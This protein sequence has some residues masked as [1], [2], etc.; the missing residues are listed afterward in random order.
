MRIAIASSGLGHVAR[1]IE[2]W[3]RTLAEALHREGED[4]ILFHGG[5]EYAC[6]NVELKFI[7][8]NSQLARLIT[9]LAPHF[10]WRWGWTARYSV[11]Q[12]SFRKK[13][14]KAIGS[15]KVD[16]L[17]VSDP[18]VAQLFER[19]R[20]QGLVR[21]RTILCHQTEE[22]PEFLA[23][24]EYVQHLA[25]WHLR[26]AELA[27][28]SQESGIRCQKSGVSLKRSWVAIPNF[29]DTKMFRPAGDE[30]ERR[31]CRL[32]FALPEEAVII[33]TVAAVK[34]HHKRIDYLIREFALLLKRGAQ[35]NG[36]P[37]STMHHP[38]FLVIAGART[39]ETGE[40]IRMADSLAPGRIKFLLDVDHTDMPALCRC[41]DVLLHG[42]LFEMLPIAVLEAM[43]TGVPVIAHHHPVLQWVIGEGGWCGDLTEEGALTELWPRIRSDLKDKGLKARRCSETSF[44]WPAVYP[45]FMA[46]YHRVVG[47]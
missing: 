33:G 32:K 13:L 4:V 19:A 24:F 25:P 39:D 17:H 26:Q 12:R 31:A 20:H 1:G 29:A 28:R 43:A 46:M 23:Q 34:K 45:Q 10:T 11:E 21:F 3:A 16:L 47:V 41:F 2:T 36:H 40:L 7:K 14:V 35:N 6:P 15:W 9:R 27:L 30:N 18:L 42:S 22:S 37:P 5:G 38:P 8:R 44:S